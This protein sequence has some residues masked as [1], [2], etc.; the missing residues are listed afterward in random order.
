MDIPT[1]QKTYSMLAASGCRFI[2]VKHHS[3]RPDGP[4]GDD[5]PNAYISVD[6]AVS[7][8][9]SNTGNVG[10]VPRGNVFVIDLDGDDAIGKFEKETETLPDFET[11]VVSTPNGAHV[12]LLANEPELINIA[13]GNTH[14]GEGVDIRAPGSNSM[15][16]GPGSFVE[17]DKPEKKSGHYEIAVDAQIAPAPA[18]IESRSR[19]ALKVR[20]QA[21]QARSN[22]VQAVPATDMTPSLKTC[23][24]KV[25]SALK[26]ISESV[27][28]ERF[29]T[30]KKFASVAGSYSV[31]Y[32]EKFAGL[33]DRLNEAVEETF[34]DSD[35]DTE[36]R[37]LLDAAENQYQWGIEH[38]YY[39]DTGKD[40]NVNEPAEFMNLI[41]LMGYEGRF[42]V[43]KESNEWYLSDPITG[44]LKWRDMTKNESA[45]LFSRVWAEH[46][47]KVKTTDERRLLAYVCRQ[48]LYQPAN[49]YL[50][51]RT[52]NPET[53]E[54]TLG[55]W[56]S[57]W[58][59]NPDGELERWAQTAMLVQPVSR[60]KADRKPQRVIV[61]LRGPGNTG[62]STLVQN[63]L[64]DVLEATG[65]LN[66]GG[67]DRDILSQLTNGYIVEFSEMRG[68]NRKDAGS[69]KSLLGAGSKKM[70]KLYEDGAIKRDYTAAIIG[71][72]NPEPILF[73]DEALISRFVFIDVK[74]NDDCDPAV[75]IP[76]IRDHL[77]ALAVNEHAAGFESNILP[78]HLKAQ[79]FANAEM[80]VNSDRMLNDQWAEVDWRLVPV[81]FK[82]LEIAQ[83]MGLARDLNHYRRLKLHLT[84]PKFLRDKGFVVSKGKHGNDWWLRPADSGDQYPLPENDLSTNRLD[85]RRTRA[86]N[87]Y[88]QYNV[89]SPLLRGPTVIKDLSELMDNSK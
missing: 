26:A 40:R 3:K 83:Y 86:V 87:A 85:E 34:T 41:S 55:N 63:L 80:S 64:P 11:F 73:D 76:K 12:Y 65:D 37:K 19:K 27:E 49:E 32:P 50:D 67:S 15:V 20:Q 4:W 36:R 28:G 54:I 42:N 47:W 59:A 30:I 78:E 61:V 22:P 29:E 88:E 57:P 66:L 53:P 71:T 52:E 82:I 44:E 46:G 48:Y 39:K 18:S 77:F 21:P 16:V 51:S 68:M 8:L 62:K 13:V 69:L 74:R 84:L 9:E 45:W 58:L 14:W 17:A 79:Q 38:P 31:H 72:A 5:S 43:E 1:L 35:S 81:R 23:R 7:R 2:R 10:V 6:Q 60:I 89:R 33:L 56:L 75:Y 70:R 25:S 24:N